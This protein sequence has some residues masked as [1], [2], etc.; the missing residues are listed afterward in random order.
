MVV[1]GCPSAKHCATTRT[2]KAPVSAFSATTRRPNKGARLGL[3]F[4]L[5]GTVSGCD[6]V[7]T[8][9]TDNSGQ[10]PSHWV[11]IDQLPVE[12]HGRIGGLSEQ[13]EVVLSATLTNSAFGLSAFGLSGRLPRSRG[14]K[15]VV[16]FV[17][18]WLAAPSSTICDGVSGFQAYKQSGTHAKVDGALCDGKIVISTASGWV[19]TQSRSTTE[20]ASSFRKIRD[21]LYW[22]LYP[23]T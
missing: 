5:L 2:K 6:T 20:L 11:Y 15:R 13:Q 17:N 10:Q 22:T 19:L 3:V 4:V 14:K 8:S 9:A 16:L 21:K 18:G 12:L 1:G 7:I 23:P